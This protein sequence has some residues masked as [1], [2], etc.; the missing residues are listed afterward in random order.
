MKQPRA[1][2]VQDESKVL[3]SN[4]PSATLLVDEMIDGGYNLLQMQDMLLR[5]T[6]TI[7]LTSSVRVMTMVRVYPSWSMYTLWTATHS[8]ILTSRVIM[9]KSQEKE[10]VRHIR[11]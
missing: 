2:D 3:I 9:R 1:I 10:T 7:T 4:A 8:N 6:D 11:K 5:D